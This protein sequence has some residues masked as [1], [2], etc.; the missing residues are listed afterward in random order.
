MGAEGEVASKWRQPFVLRCVAASCSKTTLVPS[1]L[2]LQTKHSGRQQ[3]VPFAPR[4]S[5]RRKAR[6]DRR[7]SSTCPNKNAR[8][9][10]RDRSGGDRR[11]T[12]LAFCSPCCW[13]PVTGLAPSPALFPL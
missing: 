10:T 12:S 11:S 2:A 7:S 4:W 1:R 3:R 9:Q 13:P 5:R 6:L 8:R